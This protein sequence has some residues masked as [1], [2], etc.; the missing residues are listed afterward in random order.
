[1]TDAYRAALILLI[2]VLGCFA[3]LRGGKWRW[4]VFND[5][6]CPYFLEALINVSVWIGWF[7]ALIAG[8]LVE[9]YSVDSSDPKV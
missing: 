6:R 5:K 8:I 3:I 9:G 2:P 1:M 4:K 7:V